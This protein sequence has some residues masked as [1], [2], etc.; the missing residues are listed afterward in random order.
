M[1]G[2]SLELYM[3]GLIVKDMAATLAFYRRLGL[4]IPDGSE[5]KPHVQVKMEN[6]LTLF[7]DSK[8]SRWDPQFDEQHDYGRGA[9]G[10]GYPV[11]LEFY[12]K[13]QATLEAKYAE[14]VEY[15]YEGFREP[16]LMPYGMYFAMVKDPDGN[17]ILLSADPAAG[18]TN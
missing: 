12:L 10:N 11:V 13:E 15:G 1:D 6:G 16:Y 5:T 9:A 14:L 3:V 2:M 7:F 17:A 4:A 8:P 18:E